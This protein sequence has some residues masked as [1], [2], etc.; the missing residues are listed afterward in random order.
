MHTIMP[1]NVSWVQKTEKW[2]VYQSVLVSMP[3]NTQQSIPAPV[4]A[5]ML[6]RT[7]IVFFAEFLTIMRS[8]VRTY[9]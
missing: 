2:N 8:T 7:L 5:E 4:Q 1:K 9:L 6:L 3:E